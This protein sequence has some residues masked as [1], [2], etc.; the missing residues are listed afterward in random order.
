MPIDTQTFALTRCW[1]ASGL[2]SVKE[3]PLVFSSSNLRKA[4]RDLLA[5]KNQL[6][7]IKNWLIAAQLIEKD[8]HDFKVTRYGLN[9]LRE[10]KDLKKSTSWWAFHLLVCFG[11]DPFP[12]NAFFLALD[13]DVR[14]FVSVSSIMKS[15]VDGA[16]DLSEESIKTYISGA[17][18]MFT[19]DGP[20][21][22]LGL[23][24]FARER[25]SLS[26][27]AESFW[28]CSADTVPD[29]AI[30]FAIALARKKFFVTRPS[31]DFGELLHV[32]VSHY[33]TISQDS[34]RRRLRDMSASDKWGADIRFDDVA[35][36][37]SLSFGSTFNVERMLISLLQEGGDS[38]M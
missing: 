28:R 1:A 36:I 12:Y 6:T 11:E 29:T 31:I 20:L 14:H 33:L 19:D 18:K 13:P 9:L 15:I 4:R 21:Q 35:N 37:S 17:Y 22:G 34:L 16:K 3:N 23:V 8:G 38:W 2:R 24:E 10:D 26:A 27:A 7:A 25:K 5:G 32:G 30:L